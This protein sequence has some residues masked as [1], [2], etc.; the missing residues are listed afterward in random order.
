M[1]VAEARQLLGLRPGADEEAVASAYR[2][3]VKA[4]HP[5][6]EG[7]DVERLR[8]V[9]EAHKLLAVAPPDGLTFTLMRQPAEP[10]PHPRCIGLQISVDEALFGGRRPIRLGPGRSI[11]V[12]LPPGLRSG[13]VLRLAGADQGVDLLLQI[14]IAAE[15]GMV[16]RGADVCMDVEIDWRVAQA[17]ACVEVETP[18]GRQVFLTPRASH[19]SGVVMVRFKGKGLPARGAHPAGDMVISLT[20]REPHRGPTFLRRFGHRRA[21]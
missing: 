20:V 9:I 10:R 1:T 5:D 7:G 15:P 3:A 6:R 2:A 12:R 19:D 13:D 17:G 14:A 16:V 4:A 21:A 18:R 8:R 11:V